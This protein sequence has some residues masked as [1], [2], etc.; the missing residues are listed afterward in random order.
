MHAQSDTT[1]RLDS[2][3]GADQQVCNESTVGWH[4]L[5]KTV[6]MR[7]YEWITHLET[8][9]GSALQ[10]VNDAQSKVDF[11]SLCKVCVTDDIVSVGRER[12]KS[13][14]EK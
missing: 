13:R 3:A 10:L 6:A 9:V 5:I 2:T 12:M 7:A 1:H 8:C 4:R 11:V 14:E